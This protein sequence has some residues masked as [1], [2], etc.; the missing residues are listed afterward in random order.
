MSV[1]QI[2]DGKCLLPF[3]SGHQ[4]PHGGD[5]LLAARQ[6]HD[7]KQADDGNALPD[8]ESPPLAF[9]HEEVVGVQF[10]CQLTSDACPNV[11]SS[12]ANKPMAMCNAVDSGESRC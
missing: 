6:Q 4:G 7:T 10:S 5:E 12:V 3:T 2:L 8:G 1:V 9:I 11:A